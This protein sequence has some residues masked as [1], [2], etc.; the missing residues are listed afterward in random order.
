MFN[1]FWEKVLIDLSVF[2][3]HDDTLRFMKFVLM[4]LDRLMS[5]KFLCEIRFFFIS[6][7]QPDDY[8]YIEY[9]FYF[10]LH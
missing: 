1:F 10:F 8:F 9:S 3:R 4:K 2:D 5:S 6:F 7:Y